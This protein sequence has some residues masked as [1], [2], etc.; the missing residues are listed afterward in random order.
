MA[1][2]AMRAA[3][4]GDDYEL[5]EAILIHRRFSVVAAGRKIA[6]MKT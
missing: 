4:V 3:E 6:W 1:M 2:K 5:R